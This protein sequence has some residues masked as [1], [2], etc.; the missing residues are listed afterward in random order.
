MRYVYELVKYCQFK[1]RFLNVFTYFCKIYSQLNSKCMKKLM[2]LSIFFA[3]VICNSCTKKNTNSEEKEL[4]KNGISQPMNELMLAGELAKYG[5]AKNSPLALAQAA[6]MINASQARALDST[7]TKEGEKKENVGEKVSKVKLDIAT[8]LADAISLAG[9]D[10]KLI[11]VIEDVKQSVATASR[12]RY[13]GPGTGVRRVSAGS[14][15]SDIITFDGLALAEVAIIG[16]GD[17]DL[18]L[19]VYDENGNLIG[20]DLDYTDDCY[21]SWIPK[22]TGN[23]LVKVINRGK[24]YND[25]TLVTN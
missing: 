9:D 12:G 13:E 21:V 18:D 19:F 1:I 11:A 8:L 10:V 5:Y 16:D 23:F 7:V 6:E 2:Y 3:L 15:V 17:T 24:V 4:V 22:R 14:Y 20:S 25:Y